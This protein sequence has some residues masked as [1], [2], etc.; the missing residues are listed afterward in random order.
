VLERIESQ[1]PGAFELPFV[2]NRWSLGDA[3][4][5]NVLHLSK[6]Q[7]ESSGFD[8]LKALGFTREQV[9]EANAYVCGTMTIEGAP[10]LRPE[11]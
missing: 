8:L 10:H 2:L 3:F 5:R 7:M 11:H 9:A 1:L 6:E 4:C